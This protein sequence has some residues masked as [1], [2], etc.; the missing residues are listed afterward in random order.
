MNLEELEKAYQAA[1]TEATEAWEA[2]S[3]SRPFDNMLLKDAVDAEN[4]M[5]ALFREL[6]AARQ[7]KV[8]ADEMA[9]AHANIDR[10]Q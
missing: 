10:N 3:N 2:Y 5:F 1:R 7:E 8:W 6:Q 9:E 4:K